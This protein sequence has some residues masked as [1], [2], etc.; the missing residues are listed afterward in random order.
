MDTAGEIT[1]PPRPA[2]QVRAHS[3]GWALVA[4]L[5]VPLV[6]ATAYGHANHRLER[7]NL[8]PWDRAWA[9][10]APRWTISP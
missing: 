6:G 9:R 8:A 4:A 1:A 5:T 2:E 3:L 7:H 10:T